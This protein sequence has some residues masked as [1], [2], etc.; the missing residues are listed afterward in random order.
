MA[1]VTMI[2]A[3]L[4]IVITVISQNIQFIE[5]RNLS[6]KSKTNAMM[7]TSSRGMGKTDINPMEDGVFAGT[8]PMSTPSAA[9]AVATLAPPPQPPAGSSGHADNFRPTAPGHSP[10][11]GNAIQ[12]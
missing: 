7:T 3:T 12:N 4:L 1:R 8:E 2:L 10:G 5:G 9:A 11:I 6:L